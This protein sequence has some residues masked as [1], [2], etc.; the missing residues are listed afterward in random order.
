M[1]APLLIYAVFSGIQLSEGKMCFALY[2][3][4]PEVLGYELNCAPQQIHMWKS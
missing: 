1:S 4:L 2:G 3:I